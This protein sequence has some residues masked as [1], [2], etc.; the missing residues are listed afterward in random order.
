MT[1]TI[2][3]SS[4]DRTTLTGAETLTLVAQSGEQIN[5]TSFIQN[6]M[7]ATALGDLWTALQV[8]GRIV[9]DPNVTIKIGP[10]VLSSSLVINPIN[11]VDTSGETA[12]VQAI[13]ANQKIIADN[14][15]TLL[16]AINERTANYNLLLQYALNYGWYNAATE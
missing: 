8:G 3:W 10:N 7:A 15:T 14:Q 12:A 6:A 2:I 9:Q 11:T 4:E 13:Y 16:N 1:D 5:L